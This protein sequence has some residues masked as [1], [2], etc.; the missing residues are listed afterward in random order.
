MSIDHNILY[1]LTV[2]LVLIVIILIFFLIRFTKKIRSG[3]G[4][5]MVQFPMETDKKISNLVEGLE[6]FAGTLDQ[7]IN[8]DIKKTFNELNDRL[9]TFESVAN[10]SKDELKKFKEGL[11]LNINKSLL[12]SIIEAIDFIEKIQSQNSSSSNDLQIVRDKLEIILTNNS[13]EK[14]TPSVGKNI[15]ELND[16]EPS[17]QTDPTQDDTKV[18]TISKVLSPGYFYQAAQDKKIILKKSVVT[19]F[20]KPEGSEQ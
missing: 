7:A 18:N 14:F 15:L 12:L 3:D 17:V 11:H 19:V 8:K 13:I 10:E 20:S 2:S 5:N 9:K 6:N 4:V 16:C 1:W